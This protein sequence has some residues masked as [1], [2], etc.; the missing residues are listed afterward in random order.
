[1]TLYHTDFLRLTRIIPR[2]LNTIFFYTDKF[3]LLAYIQ[4]A[5]TLH[6]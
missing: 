4:L 1:M 6:I 3:L 5:D 2:L